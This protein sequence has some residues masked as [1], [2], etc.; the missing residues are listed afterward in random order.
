MNLLLLSGGSGKRLWPLSNDVRS[1]QFLKLFKRDDGVY[2]S[3]TQ[4]VYRQAK[5]VSPEAIITVATGKDQV[6]SIRNQLG[7]QVGICVEPMRRD[8]FP[9]IAL[10]AAY[11][12]SERGLALEDTVIV[13]PVDPYVGMEYFQTLKRLEDA[14][15]AGGAN[16]TLMGVRPT[17]PS[18]KYGY[19]IPEKSDKAVKRV[20]AF[21]EKPDIE[22]AKTYIAQG[23]LWN[24]GV[25]AFRLGYLLDIVRS[26]IPFSGYRDVYDRYEELPRISFD[27]AVVEKEKNIQCIEFSGEW[28]DIGTWNT[29]AEEMDTPAIGNVQMDDACYDVQVIN[30]LDVPVLVMGAKHMVIAASMDGILVCDKERSSHI[31]PYVE[32][33][34]QRV[35]FEEKSWGSFSILSIE[36][37][38]LTVKLCVTA[39]KAMRY[40]LH[41]D[42]DEVWMV[43]TGEGKITLDG[44]TRKVSAGDVIRLP[45]G[46]KHTIRADTAMQIIE[47]QIGGNVPNG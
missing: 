2:E 1:K 25:F 8:T 20:A 35:M 31:K 36:G 33:M 39:G 38:T 19:I 17:Y 9:A 15:S 24:C 3:M 32:R 21:T 14:V 41:E 10:A 44:D 43:L 30:E 4:R 37:N 45:K 42:R 22:T 5:A 28:K 34:K 11:L 13:C 12:Q 29:L 16:L 7:D 23:A 18:E 47:T 26:H 46:V 40:H 27:Y 6:S